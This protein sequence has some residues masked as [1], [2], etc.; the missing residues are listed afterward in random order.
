M[1]EKEP[2][3][4]VEQ[5]IMDTESFGMLANFFTEPQPLKSEVKPELLKPKSG[6]LWMGEEIEL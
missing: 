2:I 5:P 6:R 4:K 1:N 3:K